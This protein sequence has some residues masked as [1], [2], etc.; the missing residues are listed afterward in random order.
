M[1]WNLLDAEKKSVVK[2]CGYCEELNVAPRSSDGLPSTSLG[3]KGIKATSSKTKISSWPNE[4]VLGQGLGQGVGV[5]HN[6]DS[7][8]DE[9][10]YPYEHDDHND[11]T[12]DDSTFYCCF[13]QRDRSTAPWGRRS[14]ASYQSR[15]D[16]GDNH[17]ENQ[18][19]E[20]RYLFLRKYLVYPRVAWYYCAILANLVLR[21]MWVVSLIPSAG[22]HLSLMLGKYL[23]PHEWNAALFYSTLLYSTLF[24]STLLYITLLYSAL[25]FR[26]LY[27]TLLYSTLL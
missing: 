8:T 1:D 2:L 20:T 21:F 7:D 19:L 3:I 6:S 16:N 11:H 23:F 9:P 10:V 26:T 25:F 22:P 14:T 15:S 18:F 13:S 17:S 4:E 5:G 12:L 24:Y 27:S